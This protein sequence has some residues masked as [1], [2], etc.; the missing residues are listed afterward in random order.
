MG[1]GPVWER[2]YGVS[3]VG[4]IVHEMPLPPKLSDEQRQQALEKAGL[5]RRRRAEVKE[6]L[7][8]GSITL[9]ELL[10]AAD[11]DEIIAK[12][13]VLTVLESL[14]GLGKVK[15]RRMLEDLGISEARRLQGLGKNQR[16]ALRKATSR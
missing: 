3:E 8:M 4:T 10:D 14:P 6:R 2:A 13:K 16:E 1:L 11:K 5:S 12:L 7:K 15:A 9:S